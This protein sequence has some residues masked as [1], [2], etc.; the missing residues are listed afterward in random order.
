MNSKERREAILL[1]LTEENK[2]LK[3]TDL[4]KIF[5]VSRQV[6][7]QDIALLRAEGRDIIATPQGYVIIKNDKTKKLKTIVSKHTSYE[8]MKEELEIMIDHGVRVVDVIVEHPIYGEIKGI[9]DIG[10]K[11]ELEE[12][13]KK[14][15]EEQAEP[16]STLTDGIHIHTI[17]VTDEKN[18]EIMK[19]TLT[20]KG[21]LINE[22]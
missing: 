3:G 21:Y 4:A 18:Y 5:N 19:E 2:S 12:F 1:K 11:K 7:V 17:E 6:I 9:L 8:E 22:E 16:L 10:Y 13:L 20:E 15:R 14:I